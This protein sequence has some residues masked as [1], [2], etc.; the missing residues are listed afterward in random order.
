MRNSNLFLWIVGIGLG[1]TI[2]F[3][4]INKSNKTET[5]TSTSATPYKPITIPEYKMPEYKAPKYTTNT[6]TATETKPKA[7]TWH[8]IDVTSY[9]KDAYNDNLCTSSTGEQRYTSDS[10]ARALDPSYTPGTSGHPYY[11]SK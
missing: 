6:Y 2:L 3:S 4:F 11:N 10:Q 7:V 5:V 8:C 1:V 9:D